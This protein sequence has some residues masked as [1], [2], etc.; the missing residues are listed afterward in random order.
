MPS[1]WPRPLHLEL[2]GRGQPADR[3]GQADDSAYSDA[4]ALGNLRFAAADAQRLMSHRRYFRCHIPGCSRCSHGPARYPQGLYQPDGI[5]LT[6]QTDEVLDWRTPT[7]LDRCITCRQW[8]CFDHLDQG[9][10]VQCR[11]DAIVM[12]CGR[13][14]CHRV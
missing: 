8:T 14:L 12:V 9:L 2:T 7:R 3:A 13:A 6:A 11:Q 5:S 10:C 1:H 4:D